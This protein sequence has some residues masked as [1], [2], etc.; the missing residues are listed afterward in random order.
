MARKTAIGILAAALAF[1]QSRPTATVHIYRYKLNTGKASHPGVSC[2]AFPIAKTE[3]GRVFTIQVSAGRHSFTVADSVT[4]G[5]DVDAEP[6]KEYFVRIDYP[7]NSSFSVG[8]KPVLVAPEQGRKEIEKLRPLD[9]W[10]VEA[11]TCG[12]P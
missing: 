2:D 1:A 8:A 6:G 12:N 11:A 5:I 9:P 7:V 3:N 4:T 10:Y